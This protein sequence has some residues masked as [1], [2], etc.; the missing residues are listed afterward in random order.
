MKIVVFLAL[1]GVPA[2]ADA[3]QTRRPATPP[4]TQASDPQAEAYQQFLLAQR[5]TDARDNDGAIESLQRAMTL[6]P[7]SDEVPAFLADLYLDLNRSDDAAKA[8]EQ[9]LDRRHNREAH[10]ILGTIYATR[11]VGLARNAAGAAANLA[12]RSSI[13]IRPP[14]NGMVCRPTRT[15]ARCSRAST[16]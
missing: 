1:L 16:S 9:A 12:K 7:S 2:L 15:F 6:D 8:A 3:A 5:L 10:R 11:D 14:S 4:V 13:S